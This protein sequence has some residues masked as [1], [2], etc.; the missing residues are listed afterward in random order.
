MLV[1]PAEMKNI[2]GSTMVNSSYFRS[3]TPVGMSSNQSLCFP[4]KIILLFPKKKRKIVATQCSLSE[5]FEI[6]TENVKN[7]PERHL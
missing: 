1:S 2:H 4:I 7:K 3:Q 6:I 5:N